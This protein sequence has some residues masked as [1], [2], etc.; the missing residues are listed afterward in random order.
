MPPLM[1]TGIILEDLAVTDRHFKGE[2]HR[3]HY[4]ISDYILTSI[5]RDREHNGPMHPAY[6]ASPGRLL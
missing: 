1:N 6:F 2:A 4:L 3:K 5:R